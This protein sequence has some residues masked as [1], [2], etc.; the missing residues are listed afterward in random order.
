MNM[1]TATPPALALASI[2]YGGNAARWR[3]EAMRSHA[4]ARLIHISKGQGRI[5]VAGLTN[6]YGPN[7][8]IYIP[9]HTMYGMEVGTTVFGQI[10]TIRDATDWP[11]TPF[12]LRLMDVDPQKE[13]VSLMEAIE[14]ELQ[15]GRDPRAAGCYFGLLTIFVDRQL[16]KRDPAAIDARRNSAAAKLVARYTALI[17]REFRADRSVGDYAADLGVTATHLSRC[18]RQTSGRSALGLLNDRIHYEA[19]VL[20]KDTKTPIQAIAKSLGFQ[21][22][23]YFTRSFQ[24]KSGQTPSDFRNKQRAQNPL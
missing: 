11:T 1:M 5:T 21:S 24:E 17:A 19:C 18:C 2:S 22:A 12:H 13:L 8:L 10:L 6:G 7:N 16:Q 20:L 15:P 3:T 14:R 9:P 23:P 4:S